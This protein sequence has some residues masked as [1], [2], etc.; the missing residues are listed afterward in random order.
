[1]IRLYSTAL[2]QFTHSFP[3]FEELLN[4]IPV[5]S[6]SKYLQITSP[7]G[8]N[9]RLIGE[10]LARF[11]LCSGSEIKNEELFFSYSGKGKPSVHMHPEMHFNI[12]H[13]GDRIVCAVGD[14]LIGIDVERIR[15]V[16][17]HIAKRY[18]SPH[19]CEDLFSLT[20]E[21]QLKY[22]FTLWT[23]KESYLKAIGEGLA[24]NLNSF[25]VIRGKSGFLLA[26]NQLAVKF[27]VRSYKLD[28]DY[29]MAVCSLEK[30]IPGRL[31][32]V[33]PQ[34]IVAKLSKFT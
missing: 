31:M 33:S 23:L 4:Y 5:Q 21:D 1:M 16:N 12:S 34:K 30:T 17:F 22:F 13:S 18:F 19:E 29:R 15:K 27:T 9:S 25:S 10:L 14:A 26:D 8:R 24:L 6:R 20:V 11:S 7:N 28:Q 32:F 3:D 2:S